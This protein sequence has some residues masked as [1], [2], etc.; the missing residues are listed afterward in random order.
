MGFIRIVYGCFI[1]RTKL[2]ALKNGDTMHLLSHL[3]ASNVGLRV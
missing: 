2:L 3:A 1:N